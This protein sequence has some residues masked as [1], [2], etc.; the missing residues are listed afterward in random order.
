MKNMLYSCLNEGQLEFLRN[1]PFG[2]ADDHACASASESACTPGASKCIHQKMYYCNENKEL[3]YLNDCTAPC[4]DQSICSP[5]SHADY[6]VDGVHHYWEERNGYPHLR[7][8]VCKNGCHENSCQCDMPSDCESSE[9]KLCV[10]NRCQFPENVNCIKYTSPAI[11]G[12]DG[13][14]YFC[15]ALGYYYYGK[16][17]D[18]S[19]KC[20]VCPNGYGGCSP[21]PESACN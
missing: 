10:D 14:A 16:T 19:S 4:L 7:P 12:G 11:C 5:A 6:C 9:A 18:Y 17:C 13:N 8:E 15:N 21:D 2:C 1:C 20:Y 3:V